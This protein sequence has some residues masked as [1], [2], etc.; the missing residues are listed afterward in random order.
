MPDTLLTNDPEQVRDF[1]VNHSEKGVI[2]KPLRG[3]PGTEGGQHVVLWAGTVTADDI[4]ESVRRT[5]H[6]FQA[7]VPRAYAVRMTIVGHRLF[8][9]RLDAPLDSTALDWRTYPPDQLLYT[10][11]DVPAD[12]SAA[13]H[14]LMATSGWSTPLPTSSLLPTSSGHSSAI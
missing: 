12:V 5:T 2:Y 11:V 4:T 7:R 1:C 8:T 6:L 14:R 3:G 13:I 10:P 9:V